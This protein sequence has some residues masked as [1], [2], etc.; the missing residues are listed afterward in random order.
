MR[1]RSVASTC[2]PRFCPALAR[3]GTDPTRPHGRRRGERHLRDAHGGGLD[4]GPI[5]L[6]ERVPIDKE[7]T[8]GE[9]HDRLARLGAD[10][11]VRALAALSRHAL[12][13]TPQAT[14]G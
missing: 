8:A 13:F 2:M 12:L 7:T 11:M 5:G 1:P 3:R 4:T 9:L 14:E 6:V 10:A